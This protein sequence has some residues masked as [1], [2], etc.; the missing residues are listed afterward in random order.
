[1]NDRCLLFTGDSF[2]A[3][4]G[5]QEGLGWVGRVVAASWEAELA[6]TA[7]NLGVRGDSTPQAAARFRAEAEPRL[8]LDADNRVVVAVGAND[9]TVEADG[10]RPISLERSLEALESLLGDAESLG[11]TALVIGAGPVGE[12]GHDA[13]S[14]ELGARF[15]ELAEQRGQRFLELPAE[16]LERGPWRA[17]ALANDGLHPGARGYA[18]YA[19]LVLAGGYLDWLRE[20]RSAA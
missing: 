11:M 8:I 19:E 12:P 4:A 9:V 14:R 18:A 20:P 15:R 1:M 2:V 16:E 17:E 13:R 10:T 3:G 5:D 6:M 7:Y